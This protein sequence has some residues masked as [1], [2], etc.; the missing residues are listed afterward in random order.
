MSNEYG[1]NN[2]NLSAASQHELSKTDKMP[3]VKHLQKHLALIE[4]LKAWREDDE[5]EQR[6]TWECLKLTLDQDRFSDRKLF[7]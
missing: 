5:Q 1:T 6:D 3:T 4:L 7:P 2:D